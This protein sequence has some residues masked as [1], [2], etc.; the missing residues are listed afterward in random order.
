MDEGWFTCDLLGIAEDG[1]QARGRIHYDGDPGNRGDH[2][3]SVRV[4]PGACLRRGPFAGR[5]VAR[6]CAD[7][8]DGN[9]RRARRSAAPRGHNDRRSVS[10]RCLD[11][12][13]ASGLYPLNQECRRLTPMTPMRDLGRAG[14]R[15][16]RGRSD[17]GRAQERLPRLPSRSG[18]APRPTATAAGSR[19]PRSAATQPRHDAFANSCLICAFICGRWPVIHH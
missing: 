11:D 13:A 15:P 19:G 12:T 7:A 18:R 10:R 9:W 3:F 4:G 8:R 1:R 16:A 5:A 14:R 17:A 6:W 2:R